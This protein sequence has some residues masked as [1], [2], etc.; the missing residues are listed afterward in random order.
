MEKTSATGSSPIGKQQKRTRLERN[1]AIHQ[2]LLDA[3][4]QVVGRVGYAE[5]SISEITKHAGVA[6]G[7]FYNHFASRQELLDQLLPKVGRDLL[8]FVERHAETFPT[9]RQREEAR[10]RAFFEFL[11]KVPEFQRILN[12]AEW[13]APAGFQAYFKVAAKG[14]VRALRRARAAGEIQS[15]SDAELEAMAYTLMGARQYLSQRYVYSPT[16]ILEVPEVV[17]SAYSKLLSE[18][19]FRAPASK[20]VAPVA[21]RKVARS[22][23]G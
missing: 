17:L 8:A 16:Q 21:P 18:G 5:A 2:R 3:A 4:T 10:F 7:T 22:R 19:F 6:Q 20:T 13:F 15:F 12:E 23:K 9:E 11:K 14:Y 1:A